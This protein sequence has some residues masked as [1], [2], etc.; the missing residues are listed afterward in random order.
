MVRSIITKKYGIND[1]F[2]LLKAGKIIVHVLCTDNIFWLGEGILSSQELQQANRFKFSHD[3]QLYVN[4]HVF[5]RETLS[6]YAPINPADWHFGKNDYGKPYID[7]EEDNGLRF[8]LSHTQ[9]LVACVIAYKRSVGI[10]VE[11]RRPLNDLEQLAQQVFSDQEMTGLL[12]IDCKQERVSCFF[13]YWTLKEA[14]IKARGIGLSL[15]LKEFSFS[16]KDGVWLLHCN[17]ECQDNGRKW[18]VTAD[19][20]RKNYHIATCV[21]KEIPDE[22]PH[23]IWRESEECSG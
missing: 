15:P 3:R 8:N 9:G 14:Y 21:E 13:A 18:A 4:A 17:P 2:Q 19:E 12:S 23:I 20:I 22:C 7:N 10:D 1:N 16:R 5:L 11:K 6:Q